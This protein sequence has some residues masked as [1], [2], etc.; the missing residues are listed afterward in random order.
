MLISR[1]L[2]EWIYAPCMQKIETLGYPNNLAGNVGYMTFGVALE[3][4]GSSKTSA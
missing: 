3:Q 1:K 4:M 2:L